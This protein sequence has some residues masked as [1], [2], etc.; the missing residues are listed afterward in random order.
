MKSILL[1]RIS[2]FVP[3]GRLDGSL[4]LVFDSN[5]RPSW[6]QVG[7]YDK[8][9]RRSGVVGTAS[10]HL[11]LQR[12]RC[13]NVCAKLLAIHFLRRRSGSGRRAT[14]APL[15][16]RGHS[17]RTPATVTMSIDLDETCDM[18]TVA[19][20]PDKMSDSSGPSLPHVHDGLPGPP[21]SRES[22]AVPHRQV[23]TPCSPRV[24]GATA[25]PPSTLPAMLARSLAAPRIEPEPM[26]N[27]GF[28]GLAHSVAGLG[29]HLS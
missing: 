20:L 17:N 29:S 13:A 24:I 25:T 28:P 27:P 14:R 26:R 5:V 8:H 3:G 23:R 9:H 6:S 10:E 22:N 19:R 11:V 4:S 15:S 21:P 1:D 16:E 12:R 7:K 18:S 2:W